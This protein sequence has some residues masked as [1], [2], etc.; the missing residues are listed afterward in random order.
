MQ[1]LAVLDDYDGSISKLPCWNKLSGSFEIKFFNKPI[2]PQ[3][4]FDFQVLVANRERTIL[5]AEFLKEASSLRHVALTGRLSGQADLETLKQRSIA[6]SYTDGSGSSAA[7]LTVALLLGVTKRLHDRHNEVRNGGWQIG[8]SQTLQGKT[9]GVLGL[10]RIGTRVAQFGKLLDMNVISW[11]PTN[12]QGKAAKLGVERLSLDECLKRSDV[13]CICL[14]LSDQTRGLLKE[15]ELRLL[16]DRSILINTA[17][18]E[19]VEKEAFYAELKSGRI[20]A[21]LDVF[22]SE[23]LPQ[24]DPI[25]SFPNVLLSP[26]M[27]YV[28]QEVYNIFFPQVVE[29]ILNWSEGR[30]YRDALH[31]Q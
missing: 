19:V 21:A 4:I 11:G 7:E 22:Y 23:P 15:K 14:R 29:N 16:R 10:G 31:A 28:T 8:P 5:N 9:L 3:E 6:V 17:R 1:K 27:G 12:D 18:A 26:H 20:G 2:H 24:D 13:V 25:R 30:D